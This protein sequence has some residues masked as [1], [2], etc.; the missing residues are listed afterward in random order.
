MASLL[1]STILVSI[2]SNVLTNNDVT[3]DILKNEDLEG[4]I[5]EYINSLVREKTMI[6]E[7]LKENNDHMPGAHVDHEE[8]VSHPVNCYNLLKRMTMSWVQLSRG[9]EE[10]EK[11]SLGMSINRAL[12]HEVDIQGESCSGKSCDS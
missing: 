3:N 9:L 1:L 5:Q 10:L 7:F 12:Q 6:E 11:D 2:V 8:Y 4:K